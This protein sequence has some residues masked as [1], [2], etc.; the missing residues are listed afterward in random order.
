MGRKWSGSDN[1]IVTVVK[2]VRAVRAVRAVRVVHA[3]VVSV[4]L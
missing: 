2:V 3:R 4:V 1:V